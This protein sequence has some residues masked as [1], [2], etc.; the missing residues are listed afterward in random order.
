MPPHFCS[1]SRR[2]FLAGAGVGLGSAALGSLLAND[3][4]ATA[5]G[6]RIAGPHFAPK[7]KRVIYLHMIGAPSHLDLFDDKPVLRK[8]DGEK[9]PEDLLKG[10]RF[11][12]IGGEMALAGSTYRFQKHG[13]SGAELSELLPH[14]AGVADDLCI[15]K[16]MHTNEINHAPAQ[17]FLHTGFGQG[18]RPSLGAW[19]TY[20]LGADNQDL[21]AYVVLLSG[22][23]GGAGT[24]LWGTGFLP[25]RYQGVQFRGSG[26]PVLFLNNPEGHS[27]QD[28]RQVLDAVRT[29]N[30]ERLGLV[31]DPEIATRISQYEMAYRMQASVPELMDIAGESKATLAMYGAE[32][33]RAS[34]AN[35]CLLARRLVERGVRMVQ[36]YDSDWDHHGNLDK[37][38]RAKTRDVDQPM[39]ALVRDLKQR[40]LLEDTLV[41]WGSE[42]GRT[43]LRQGIDGSG[44]KT[45][46]G[47]DHH[48]DAFTIWMAGGGVRAG[49]THGKTDEF[50]FSVVEGGV[51]VHD[52]NATVLHLMGLDHE[53]LTFRYQ[54]RD[55]RLTDVHG[56]IVRPILA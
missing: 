41:I 23:P 55:F 17:M 56:E 43:P 51:H 37:R 1:V 3:L 36:L 35:N 14:L 20:G 28:R 44:A 24:S 8:H 11:A 52:L 22:P 42:F 9:C 39:A 33:G 34:F 48:K 29:L 26:E 21:P 13:R 46:P 16:G 32:P 25:S 50:G 2:Q 53:R 7:A 31:G 54:G 49:I 10:R 38:L 15:L 47:R 4:P 40:G 6:G 5:S 30:E 18:G 27:R 12:F 45:S 19:T